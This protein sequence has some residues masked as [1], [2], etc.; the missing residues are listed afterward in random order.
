MSVEVWYWKTSSGARM[1][2]YQVPYTLAEIAAACG[3]KSH[4]SSSLI[5][6]KT[7]SANVVVDLNDRLLPGPGS[8][9]PMPI[10]DDFRRIYIDSASGR[11]IGAWLSAR[12]GTHTMLKGGKPDPATTITTSAGVLEPRWRETNSTTYTTT[13]TLTENAG[14]SWTVFG[15]TLSGET[16]FIV[17]S[18]PP[19]TEATPHF[20]TTAERS[21]AM[22]VLRTSDGKQCQVSFRLQAAGAGYLAIV[23]DEIRNTPLNELYGGDFVDN[24]DKGFIEKLGDT[25]IDPEGI[26]TRY[27]PRST[28]NTVG[29]YAL[30]KEDIKNL[31][32]DLWVSDAWE[33]FK[34]AFMGEGSDAI[35]GLQWLYGIKPF[36]AGK[37]HTTRYPVSIGNTRFTSVTVPAISVDYVAVNLGTIT[38]PT[39]HGNHLDYEAVDYKCYIPFV[40]IIDMNPQD[41][42]GRNLNLTYFVNVTDG[43]A[44]VQISH[45][46]SAQNSQG[47]IF[48]AA[49]QWGY[50]I[51]VKVAPE[52]SLGAVALRT[53]TAGLASDA[54][55][56]NAGSLS[57]NTAVMGDFQ[58]KMVAIKRADLSSG[59][60]EAQGLPTGTSRLVSEETGYFQADAVLNASTLPVRKAAEIVALLREGVYM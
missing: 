27:Q 54:P 47:L 59:L 48:Q 35:L 9:L 14:G 56:Y 29:I 49:C 60:Q 50:D 8:L 34:Q 22:A 18:E 15:T 30:T 55:S 12:S 10:R 5:G 17:K 11:N 42:V 6:V 26:V 21:A 3:S 51:P 33:S 58:A 31:M 40:G 45:D 1:P 57:G 16:N 52:R 2:Y 53:L 46:A 24:Y 43:S 38:V 20:L 36:L 23:A 32:A 13:A 19:I 37:Y 28:T 44:V 4:S 41:V 7:T 25:N 39:H